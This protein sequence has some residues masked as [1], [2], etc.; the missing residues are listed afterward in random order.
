M[1]R[2]H[3]IILSLSFFSIFSCSKN[4]GVVTESMVVTTA[5]N[6]EGRWKILQYDDGGEDKTN[7]FASLNVQ[8]NSNGSLTVSRN[9]TTFGGTWNIQTNPGLDKLDILIS[10]GTNPYGILEKSWYIQ[11]KTNNSL[12]LFHT[13]NN[14]IEILELRRS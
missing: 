12:S 11:S 5:H 13:V 9:D 1:K 4:N 14:H 3:F 10:T 2:L 6:V 7:S 8:F